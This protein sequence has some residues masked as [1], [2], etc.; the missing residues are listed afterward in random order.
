[1]FFFKQKTAY[2]I[3]T[4]WSSDVC[5]SD[6]KLGRAAISRPSTRVGGFCRGEP[7]H[8]ALRCAHHT[9]F[10]PKA[11]LPLGS[12]KCSQKVHFFVQTFL[13]WAASSNVR[14]FCKGERH[15]GANLSL[16]L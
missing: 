13:T 1:F 4:D 2:E 3:F 5:S 7:A 11:Q 12:P 8:A 9:D 10:D 6:L 14:V 15:F 16:K